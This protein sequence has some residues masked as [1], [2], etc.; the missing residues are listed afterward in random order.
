VSEA[1]E[2]M[3]ARPGHVHISPAGYH[4]LLEADETF[5]LSVDAKV[6]NVRPAIDVLFE[7]A[8]D[9]WT[10]GLIGVIL[11]GANDD[12]TAGLKAIKAQGGFVIA[13]DPDEAFADTMPRSAIAAGVVDCV[14][15]LDAIGATLASMATPVG[16]TRQ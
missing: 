6:R 8:A 2:K 3:P 4:L 15:P 12:G 9:V 5:A 14:L 16:R 10:D 13:E 11:T 1:E 7:S